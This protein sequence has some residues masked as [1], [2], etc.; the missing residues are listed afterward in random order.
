MR[1][2]CLGSR[3]YD[4]PSLLPAVE[5]SF[6]NSPIVTIKKSPFKITLGYTPKCH[7][8]NQ[9][10][11]VTPLV[12]LHNAI[13][14]SRLKNNDNMKSFVDKKRAESQDYTVNDYVSLDTRNPY[15]PRRGKVDPLFVGPFR[16][17]E[18]F[19]DIV[20]LDLPQILARIHGYFHVLL[21]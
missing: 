17:L 11:N 2:V 19:A 14:A 1:T 5:F 7:L 3:K 4:R 10:N 13:Y 15:F 8:G 21:L 12:M 6:N 18:R 16:V 9:I 20:K